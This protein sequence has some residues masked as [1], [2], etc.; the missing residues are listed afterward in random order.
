MP[1]NP[2]DAFTAATSV[3][4]SVI[5]PIYR[6]ADTVRELKDRLAR[7]L[8][9]A[10]E[11]FEILFVNDAC[12]AGSLDVLKQL[13]RED[14]RV[15]VLALE[16]NIGQH[17]AVLAGLRRTRS[18]WV[19]IM[20]ADL[21]DPPEAIPGLL[22]RARKGVDVVFAG[23]R[24][25]YESTGR[26]FTS[27][28]FKR[29]LAWLCNLPADAG[30]FMV[31]SRKAATQVSAMG[32]KRPFVVAM[33]GC[34]GLPMASIPVERSPRPRGESAYG[35]WGRFDHGLRAVIWS[36][37]YKLGLHRARYETLEPSPLSGQPS[38]PVGRK[39]G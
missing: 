28:L 25:Q 13:A 30:M 24:G 10:G 9:D 38:D 27:R 32:G 26:L 8:S 22:E 36:L 19:I 1:K 20:D 14:P 29:T 15:K 23:R 33:I 21:Q 37:G 4:V 2:N 31:A 34:T 18:D 11:T 39:N 35:P 3:D 16:T 6:N 17:R 5:L 7:T 12:P